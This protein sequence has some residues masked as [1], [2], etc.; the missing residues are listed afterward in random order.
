MYGKRAV[1]A[2]SW[3]DVMQIVQIRTVFQSIYDNAMSF[4]PR[5]YGILLF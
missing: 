3:E 4:M 1:P 2:C 5:G